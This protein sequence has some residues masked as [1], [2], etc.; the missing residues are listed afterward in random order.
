MLMIAALKPCDIKVSITQRPRPKDIKISPKHLS[1]KVTA[2]NYSN[3]AN[4]CALGVQITNVR[5]KSFTFTYRTYIVQ[6]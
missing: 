5:R 1:I 2:T 4:I 6:S 3:S